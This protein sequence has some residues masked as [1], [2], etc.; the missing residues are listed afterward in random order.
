MFKLAFI[1]DYVKK[2]TYHGVCRE[3]ALQR[4]KLTFKFR[5]DQISQKEY[6]RQMDSIDM[7]YPEDW[8][9]IQESGGCA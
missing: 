7:L 2:D 1:R 5:K 4:A 8:K 3:Y 9:K 6:K